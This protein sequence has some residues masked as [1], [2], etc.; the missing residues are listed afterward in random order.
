[1]LHEYRSRH[2]LSFAVKLAKLFHS[3]IEIIHVFE[4]P[5]AYSRTE[6]TNPYKLEKDKSLFS[7]GTE[8]VDC[9]QV[10]VKKKTVRGYPATAIL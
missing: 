4:L 6:G 7:A 5:M 10:P 1:M 9:G 2:A 3:E 8:G